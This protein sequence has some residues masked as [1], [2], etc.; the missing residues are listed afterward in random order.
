MDNVDW[1]ILLGLFDNKNI[2]KTG[3]ILKLSQ[4]AITHRMNKLER[5]FEVKFFYRGRKGVIFTPQG[6]MFAHY[7]IKMLK[8]YQFVKEDLFNFGNKVQGTLRLSASSI[9]SRYKLPAILS[10]FSK[11]YPLV[12]FDVMT[13][14]SED[15]FNSIY[16]GYSQVGILRGSYSLP[17]I[18][19]LLM[20]ETLYIVSKEPI[21]LED[22]PKLPRIYYNTD[23][24]LKTL[25]DNW[26]VEN[27]EDPSHI[28]MKVDNMETCKEFVLKGLGFAVLPNILLKDDDKL[29]KTPCLNQDGSYVKRETWLILKK[30]YLNNTVVKA[31]YDFL[32]DWI[33]G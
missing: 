30:E 7:A 11:K 29:Y 4:P 20:Q 32:H 10:E 18:K 25:I 22:L 13:G 9:F 24:S 23:T 12:E 2:T 31:F 3:E 26:W 15:V 6:E 5:E 14:W 17:S 27:Y 28:T 1:E 16:K 8:E 21:K 33:F 19:K